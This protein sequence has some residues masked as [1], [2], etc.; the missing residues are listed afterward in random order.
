M[1]ENRRT[2]GKSTQAEIAH[3]AARLLAEGTA[4]SFAEAKRKAAESLGLMNARKLPENIA[5]QEALI[6]YQA[7]FGGDAHRERILAMRRAALTALQAL[8]AFEPRLVGPVLYGTACE[9][10]P[11]TLHL[12]TDEVEAVIRY[13][14]DLGMAYQL[15]ETRLN[16]H[17]K[18]YAMFP[19]FAISERDYDF[20]IVV[21]PHA[22]LTH[23]PLSS[24]DGKPFRRAT[25]AT[26][27]KL[28]ASDDPAGTQPVSG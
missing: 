3:V 5:V 18:N 6:D 24:L 16:T 10:S 17:G 1:R 23:A 21:L 14:H 13:F 19:S 8:T 11:V 12:H 4:E 25:A 7:L 28:L 9:Y 20:D 2:A 26:L 15:D 22:C 27:E